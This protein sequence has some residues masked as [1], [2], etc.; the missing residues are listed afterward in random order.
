MHIFL[1]SGMNSADTN[2]YLISSGFENANVMENQ[3]QRYTI[4]LGKKNPLP[5]TIWVALNTKLSQ[6]LLCNLKYRLKNILFLY[7]IEKPITLVRAQ[8]WWK[9]IQKFDKSYNMI[10]CSTIPVSNETPKAYDRLI[11]HIANKFLQK[12]ESCVPHYTTE[13][14]KIFKKFLSF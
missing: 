13:F 3:I 5:V 11:S 12:N 9:L 10:L 8:G 4:V 7:N 1:L 6:Y 2:K 14:N